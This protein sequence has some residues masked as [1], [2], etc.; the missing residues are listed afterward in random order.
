MKPT[1][2]FRHYL[3]LTGSAVLTISYAHATTLTWDAGGGGG[4]ITNGAGAWLGAGLW[5]KGGVAATWTS[6]D[7]AIFAGPATN[8]GAV[9]L[10]SPTVAN[11]LTF[12]PSFAG[13]YTLGTAG[14]ALTINNGITKNAGSGAVT[15]A[16][17]TTLGGAQTWTNNSATT[18]QVNTPG[19][20]N[21]GH[22]FTIDG[23]GTTS[24]G[25]INNSSFTLA[26]SGN[27][28]KNGDGRFSFGG[29]NT[30]I[31]G[32]VTLNGGV[33]IVTGIGSIG[34]G[35]LTMNG[36][37]YE[38]YWSNTFTRT[39]GNTAGQVQITGGTSG[40]GLNGATGMTVRL[41]NSAA[42]EVVWG[43]ALFNPSTF[44]LQ[45]ASAQNGS[46]LT[47]DNKIDLN[48]ADRTIAQNATNT[49]TATIAQ[50]IR[51]SSG[52]AGIIKTGPGNLILNATN[53]YDGNTAVNEGTLTANTSGA[54]PG[55][56]TAGKVSVAGNA[57]LTVRTAGWT[58]ANIDSLRG[59]ATWSATTS[60]LGFDTSGG[61]FTYGSNITEALSV[62]K[63]GTNTLTLTGNS[64]YTGTTTVSTGT[65]NL[66]GT[67]SIG[68]VNVT[69]GLFTVDGGTTTST[70][71]FAL[72]NAS[73]SVVNGGTLSTSS[74]GAAAAFSSG[75]SMTVT[76]GN[77]V[78][79]TWNL[80]GGAIGTVANNHNI[81]TFLIDGAGFPGSARVTNVGALTWGRTLSN[82]TLTLTN[83]GQMNVSGEIRTGVTYY[84]TNGNTDVVIGGGTATSTFTGNNQTF[85]IGYA[86]RNGSKKMTSP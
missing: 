31:S 57:T 9:T 25:I 1:A 30:G 53:T 3:A 5:N 75:S 82:A 24:F 61:S 36:G 32:N 77:G 21:A 52:K 28:V 14:Q 66:T 16:S 8:G 6:G 48:G 72:P 58:A 4:A 84:N 49:A 17:P 22:Q 23:T 10:A 80:N 2:R 81:G 42:F 56:A 83:G 54:L 34:S 64:T 45:A 26:G 44:V 33:T 65:L 41:N 51:T 50:A 20:T 19:M 59:A 86:E 73:V 69:A 67:N 55:F 38:E 70:G 62:T 7:D 85:T 40:F 37:V 60:R 78:T 29:N 68:A 71:T 27:L 39:L 12:S 76:G 43:R 46:G 35:N 47:F 11:T 74:G 63:L 15:I 18:L 79:S 13:T